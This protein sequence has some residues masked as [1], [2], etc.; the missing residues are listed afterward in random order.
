VEMKKKDKK[1]KKDYYID[2]FW[3]KVFAEFQDK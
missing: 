2:R 3:Q 1:D